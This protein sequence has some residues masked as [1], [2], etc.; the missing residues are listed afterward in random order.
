VTARLHQL[1]V[2]GLTRAFAAGQVSVVAATDHY[3]ARI[4]AHDGA[5]GAFNDLDQEGARAAAARSAAR[6]EA[7]TPRPLEGVPIA[8]KANLAVRSLPHHGGF[9]AY[10]SRIAEADC[11]AV[12]RLREAGA[13]ILGTLN[14][15]EGA[16][17]AITA[18]PHFGTTHNP[19]RIGHTPGGSSGGS[20]AAVAAGLCAAALGTDT[21]GSIRIPA[22][23]CGV[24]GLKPT[25]GLVPHEGLLL[26]VERW[27]AIGPLARSV[28]DL[29]AVMAALAPLGPSAPARRIA[30]LSSV[31]TVECHPAV[32]AAFRLAR[33]LLEGLGLDL[34]DQATAIDHHRV[35]LAGFVAAAREA[36]ARYGEDAAR[37]PQ[38]FSAAFRD[39]LAFGRG[40]DAGAIEKGEAAIAEAGEALR[41]V[42]QLAD[43]VLLPTAPQPAFAH[44]GPP[45][46]PRP[47]SPR[48]PTSRAFPPSPSPPA[49]PATAFPSASSSSAA[50]TPRRPCSRLPPISTARS[51]PTD[52]RSPTPKGTPPCASSSSST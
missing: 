34:T 7:G 44:A 50:R 51:T 11:E 49:G 37:L 48:S 47:T 3:L 33:D 42:L 36:D 20:G 1:G 30:T 40:F 4:A 12:R 38:G 18:N 43:A 46:S 23:Y 2:L 22:A 21:L 16:L 24:Y 9:G 14:L 13:V 15:H 41:A 10:A 6:Y 35:R 17:G 8:V 52:R 28:A 29:G 19:H 5:I 39:S 26:L 45:R 27:D 32:R 25:N 31:E